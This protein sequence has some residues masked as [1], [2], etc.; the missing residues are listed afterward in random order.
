MGRNLV[1][2]EI[3]KAPDAFTQEDDSWMPKPRKVPRTHR[4]IITADGARGPLCKR[5]GDEPLYAKS[6]EEPTCRRCAEILELIE[7]DRR[8]KAAP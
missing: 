5:H 8:P 3:A 4:L 1:K 7:A 6:A 2:H